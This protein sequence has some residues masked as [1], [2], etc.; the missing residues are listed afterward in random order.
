MVRRAAAENLEKMME[1]CSPKVV[2]DR[3]KVLFLRMME[4]EQVSADDYARA[5]RPHIGLGLEPLMPSLLFLLSLPGLRSH[6]WRWPAANPFKPH[7]Q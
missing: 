5:I 7:Q 3:L 4:D 2:E 1:L 6:A